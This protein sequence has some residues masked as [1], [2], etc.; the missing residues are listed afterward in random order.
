MSNYELPVSDDR[1]VDEAARTL[2][3]LINHS[4]AESDDVYRD[5]GLTFTKDN[6]LALR[7]YEVAGLA[8]PTRLNDVVNYLG[9]RTGAGRGLEATDF[10]KSFTLIHTHA[11]T[12]NPLRVDLMSV[13]HRLE[14]FAG[15]M[16]Q[17]GKSMENIVDDM[18]GARALRDLG[19]NNL[20]DLRQYE[21]SVGHKFPHLELDNWDKDSISDFSYILDMILEGVRQRQAE[22][23]GIKTRLDAF[24]WTLHEE[25]GPEVGRKIRMI[26]NNTLS[27]DI[28]ALQ[29]DIDT[30]AEQIDE[31]N[32]EY[33][34]AVK[35]AVGSAAGGVVG[36]AVAI[37]VGV[38]AERI[39]KARNELQVKQASDIAKL[40][41]K[42]R[43][44]GSL[45]R[46]RLDLQNMEGIILDADEATKN[47]V[48]SWNSIAIFAEQ[49]LREVDEIT[50]SMGVR[51]FQMRFALVVAPWTGI[52]T[53]SRK[54]NDVFFEAN[55]E[56]VKEHRSASKRFGA[57]A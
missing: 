32:A 35:Q 14:L 23:Q 41:T 4:A 25:V 53:E 1:I 45:N 12:W 3:T 37:Y 22:A 33:K 42:H 39:R 28:K 55:E 13:A 19:I 34:E 18:G 54:L 36:L 51:R 5:T 43:I 52:Q 6:L 56:F 8:L 38:E 9:Y 15:Q 48:T 10:Q 31:K 46:V 30:R 29:K 16:V 2:S 44:L 40:Q 24:A 17:H 11:S 21:M 57:G 26:D 27:V 20:A 49:S 47:L 50:D 7:R